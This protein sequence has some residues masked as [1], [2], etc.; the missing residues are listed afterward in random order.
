M[1]QLYWTSSFP[2]V[3]LILLAAMAVA[4]AFW[5][6]R[7]TLP[8][9]S[10]KQR[11]VLLILRSSALFFLFFLLGK[12]ILT[13]VW[14]FV[15]KP[16]IVLLLDNSKSMR[17]YENNA[18]KVQEFLRLPEWQGL[19]ERAALEVYT[20][21]AHVRAH[22]FSE[23]DTLAFDDDA[24]RMS[25][26]FQHIR[27][28]Y[29]G[30]KL[31]SV[32]LVSDGNSTDEGSPLYDALQCGVPVYT[33]GVGDTLA[34]K[35]VLLKRVVT[36]E[37]CYSGKRVPVNVVLHSSGCNGEKVDVSL[38]NDSGVVT[39]QS[40][41]LGRGEQDYSVTLFF[42]PQG[43]GIQKY[44]VTVSSVKDEISQK[45]NSAAFFIKALKTKVNVLFIAGAP[46]PDVAFFRRT[47]DADSSYQLTF[48][49]QQPS[50][51]L[52]PQLSRNM[53]QNVNCIVLAGYPTQSSAISELQI[54]QNYCSREPKPMFV[55]GSRIM[56]FQKL[57]MICSYL[58][59]EVRVLQTSEQTVFAAVSERMQFHPVVNVK[60]ENGTFDL[61]SKLPP[62][63][64]LP[65]SVTIKEGSLVL[66]NATVRNT[67]IQPLVL[68][69]R[70]SAAK[71]ILVLGYGVWRWKMLSQES[72]AAG[73]AY[74]SF[75]RNS[76]QW[77]TT[78]EDEKRIRIQPFRR[79]F[80]AG[81]EIVF[82]AQLYDEN[83]R[84]IDNADITVA[85][86]KGKDVYECV[87]T[88]LGN[89][90]YEGSLQSLPSGEYR[91][92]ARAT[93]QNILLGQ[94][95]G[96]FSVGE[97]QEEFLRTTMNQQLLQQLA[98]RTG[99]AFLPI[100]E[101]KK[102]FGQFAQLPL[103]SREYER[104]VEYDLTISPWILSLVLFLFA[105]EW[106]LRKR[107]GLL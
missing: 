85:I 89:G 105:C 16:R 43:E 50:G 60:S 80:A 56:D 58:P 86:S 22:T 82:Q 18:A 11:T 92:R 101:G 63:F 72:E 76:L 61:W 98:V 68:A 46:S 104:T 28:Q 100:A 24:T 17:F 1:P 75:V 4:L 30:T 44:T 45:N 52:R 6:Y 14:H 49:V 47:I 39:T 29:A 78:L 103:N 66:L 64:L 7:R 57:G 34:W 21:G 8:P 10:R 5:Y 40:L 48:L 41:T 13:A 91:Y 97:A 88:S 42:V 12:P 67:I 38:R 79:I 33:L 23:L 71:S 2:A 20:F 53:L 54:L 32:M 26:A 77:L 59:A 87:L 3:L 73:I 102:F 93:V 84:T 74:E 9:L 31:H 94:S 99:G 27:Q 19:M 37:I 69:R 35:D 81:D 90:Q 83:Y 65:S 51:T 107:Y 55:L 15:E 36:N 70:G 62:I 106:F 95:E 96:V 25:A